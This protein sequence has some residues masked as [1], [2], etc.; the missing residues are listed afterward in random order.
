VP[1]LLFAAAGSFS[2]G[3]GVL[4][5]VNASA[6]D[7]VVRGVG[8]SAGLSLVGVGAYFIIRATSVS[9]KR[10]AGYTDR[11]ERVAADERSAHA[12]ELH[13]LKEDHRADVDAERS[14]RET[15]ERRLAQRNARIAQLNYELRRAGVTLPPWSLVPEDLDDPDVTGPDVDGLPDLLT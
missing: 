11:I 3:S 12:A 9:T 15:A 10:L 2:S 4:A 8:V 7:D 14:R 13:Q 6:A 1:S 5:L